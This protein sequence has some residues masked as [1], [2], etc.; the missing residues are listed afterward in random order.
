MAKFGTEII[1]TAYE[2]LSALIKKAEDKSKELE[3]ATT[4]LIETG[5][6]TPTIAG[7]TTAGTNTYSIQLGSYYKIG[8]RVFFDIN[9]A[10]SAKDSN[11]LGNISIEG[12]P[13]ISKGGSTAPGYSCNVGVIGR[14]SYGTKKEIGAVVMRGTNR[15]NFYGAIEN[16]TQVQL[17]AEDLNATFR[18]NVSGNYE[19]TTTSTVEE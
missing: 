19:I 12:L 14:V 9:L 10:M 7:S 1:M 17:T 15:I 6:F 16:G 2:K 18:V 5:T 3:T 4:T 8:N 13:Y 11:M